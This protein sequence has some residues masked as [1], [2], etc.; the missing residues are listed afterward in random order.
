MFSNPYCVKA[1]NKDVDVNTAESIIIDANVLG[2]QNFSVTITNLSGNVITHVNL[3]ASADQI[4]YYTVET[5]ALINIDPA[6]TQQYTFNSVNK[7][8][9]VTAMS[10]GSSKIECYVIGEV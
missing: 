3:Y 5:D 2:F 6:L 4:N 9:R 10:A 7:F 1:V 8:L